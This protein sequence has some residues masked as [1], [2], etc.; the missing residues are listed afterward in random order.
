MIYGIC[1]LSL[2]P[3]RKNPSDKSE[4]VN[5]LLFGE[6]F[7]IIKKEEKWQLE[8]RKNKMLVY[9]ELEIDGDFTILD[10]LSYLL[11]S[12]HSEQLEGMDFLTKE[13]FKI[14]LPSEL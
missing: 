4:M 6:H 12:T 9:E 3:I 10:V 14:Y 11:A 2:I 5:Q 13:D 1:E 7:K 8:Y